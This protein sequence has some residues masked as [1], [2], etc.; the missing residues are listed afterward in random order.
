MLTQK[1][2]LSSLLAALLCA[3]PLTGVRAENAVAFVTEVEGE[4]RVKHPK[5]ISEVAELGT[6]LVVGD[7]VE[8]GKGRAIILFLSGRSVTLGEG[9]ACK[10]EESSDHP[11]KL[12]ARAVNVLDEMVRPED[13][14]RPMVLG[15]SRDLG[16]PGML[17]AHTRISTTDFPF[18]WD[19]V[20]GIEAYEFSLESIEGEVLFQRTTGTNH[21][22]SRRCTLEYGRSYMWSVAVSSLLSSEKNRIDIVSREEA[23]ELD[24]V[25]QEIEKG[26]G[27]TTRDLL[28]A[29]VYYEGGYYYEAERVLVGLRETPRVQDMLLA[30]YRKMERWERLPEPEQ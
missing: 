16:I 12:M 13:M 24:S 18:I 30:L 28:K 3:M 17:P 6:Q 1:R 20:K 25:V 22:S 4:V 21:L 26:Y 2:R 27:G 10:I 5:G 9:M 15:M 14:A 11:A 29:T 23:A 19:A 8:A 7:E